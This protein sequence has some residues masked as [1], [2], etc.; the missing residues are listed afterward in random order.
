MTTNT[1]GAEE[2]RGALRE[3]SSFVRVRL[4]SDTQQLARPFAIAFHADSPVRPLS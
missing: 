1:E 2:I 3:L 4:V